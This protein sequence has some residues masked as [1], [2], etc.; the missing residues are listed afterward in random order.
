MIYL[1]DLEKQQPNLKLL[2]ITKIKWNK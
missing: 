1:K 2:E